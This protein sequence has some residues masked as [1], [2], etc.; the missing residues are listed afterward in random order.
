MTP[1]T[2]YVKSGDV[3]IAYQVVG[4]GPIDLVFV[5]GFVSHLELLWED[6]EQ[7]RFYQRLASFCRLILF[8]KRGTG[9]SDRVTAIA[10]LEQRMDDVRAVIDAVGSERIA[11]MG[12]S[13]G[14]P[15]SILFAAT[16][17]ERTSALITYGTLVKGSWAED[18]PWEPTRAEFEKW[19]EV[20][21]EEWPDLPTI[22]SRAPSRVDDEPFKQQWSRY[23]RMAASPGA[24]IDLFRMNMEIDVRHILPAVHVPTLVLHRAED[25]ALPIAVSQY[26][27][28]RIPGARLVALKGIDHLWWIGDSDAIVDEVQDFLTGERRTPEPDR[29]L[30]TV[31]FTDIVGST[32]HAVR[33]GDARWHDLIVA[34]DQLV[35]RL[36]EQFRGRAV[37]STGDGYMATFDGPARAVRCAR[38]ISQAVRQ[39]GINVRAGLHAGEIELIGDDIGGVA[40]HTAAR[41]A[42]AAGTDEVLVSQTVR[43]LVSGSGLGFQDRGVHTLKGVPGEWRLYRAA[44]EPGA[45]ASA[46]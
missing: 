37:R 5:P 17:P 10:D 30:A 12:V 7:A 44:D 22:T 19:F 13:E 32:D 27:A 28:A 43:D 42:A 34:H 15:M 18:Y 45:S 8:D 39:L 11:L 46:R 2:R 14:G 40:V 23:L 33:L 4:D 29:V 36:I 20:I 25:R 31:M 38:A 6:P 21:S 3:H 16:Y 26:L 41:V 35:K 9:M 1:K 24:V